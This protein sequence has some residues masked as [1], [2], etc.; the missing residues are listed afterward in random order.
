MYAQH[1]RKWS[2]KTKKQLMP[3]ILLII[4]YML[5]LNTCVSSTTTTTQQ[6]QHQQQRQQQL[7]PRLWEGSAEESSYY[8]PLSSDNG[9]GSSESAESSSSNIDNNI[10][11]RLLSRT[12]NSLSSRSN[13]KLKPATV[14]DA[15]SSSAVQQE[16]HVAAVPEQQQ[17]EQQSMQK[18]PNTLINSQINNLLYNGMPIEAASSKMR[19]HIQ[20]TQLQ[21]QP[22]SLAQPPSNYSTRSVQSYLIES[23]EVPESK[24][25]DRSLEQTARSRRDGSNTN[26]SRQQHPHGHR[27]QLQQDKRDHRRQRQ[28]QQKEQRQ[29]QHQHQG[30]HHHQQQQHQQNK[31]RR[32][33]Q[34]KHRGHQRSDRYCS[35]RDPAQLAFAAPTVF[36]GVFKSMSADRRVNF[37]ATMKVEKVYK[38]QHDLQLPTLVR[39]QFALSNS[40]GECDIY[41]ERLLPR[42]LLRSGN[43]LQQASDISYMMFVQQTNPGNF[44]ILGQ[45]I[46]VTHSVVESVKM[47]VSENYAQ[48][49]SITSITSVPNNTTIEHGRELKIVCKVTGQPP[50]KVT[51]FKDDKSINRKRNV[52]QFKHHKR[53]SELIVRSFNS[54]SDAGKY[55]CRAK[56]KASKAIFKRRIMIKASAVLFPLDQSR[57]SGTPCHFAFCLHGGTCMMIADLN[58]IFCICPSDYFGER[59]EN[60]SP[61][62]RYFVAIYG[63]IH[64]L[65]NV[66]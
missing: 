52:Y 29:H 35:A 10:L 55:E 49:A 36:Q 22:E 16:Q 42:G 23:F 58:A 43:D 20:P 24:L 13:V 59:C 9:S 45:P 14:F 15:G 57:S 47:A 63:Q 26:G 30:N 48:N 64:T 32:K 62:S 6:Q 8:I 18:V 1:L 17:Q 11:S 61:D 3:L 25:E 21:H 19:R 51:W 41:R 4:S 60:N 46:R 7:Q 44:T 34:R 54:S 40:S 50:P 53:R 28:H 65:N 5:L 38:Q 39:L 33:H 31:Q 27:K 12:S 2:L 66:Y 37:S 56:N